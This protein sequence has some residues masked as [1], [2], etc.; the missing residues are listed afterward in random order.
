MIARI[1]FT[2]VFTITCN[3]FLNAQQGFYK[4]FPEK[5]YHSLRDM[6]VINDNHFAFITSDF[7]YRIDGTGNILLKKEIGHGSSS[8]V[9]SV[10]CD[11]EGNFWIAFISYN[12]QGDPGKVLY[13]FSPNGQVLKTIDLG[14]SYSVE[15]MKLLASSNN[16]FFLAYKDR[17]PSGNT[18]VRLSLLD[19]AGNT[20]WNKQ[21]TDTIYNRYAIK[22][23][24]NNTVDLYYELK[25]DRQ[26][27]IATIDAT[28]NI[29]LKKINL[30]DPVD[31]DYYTSD[32]VRTNDGIVFC[33][34]ENKS[35]PSLSDGLIYKA[36]NNGNILWQNTLNIKLSDNFYN[37][38]AVADG[39]IILSITGFETIA[40]DTEGDIVMIKIDKQGNKVWTKAFG[41]PKM[42]YARQLYVAGQHIA[43]AGQSSYPASSVSVPFVCKTDLNGNISSDLPF[44]P[45]PAAK[46]KSIET[47]LLQYASTMCQS[48]PGPNESI[49]SGGNFIKTEDDYTYPFITRSDKNAKQIWYKQLADHP[50]TLKVLKQ[51]RPNEYIA[52]T[53]MKDIFANLYDVY[54]LDETGKI[55]WT[56]QVS[57]SAIRDVIA[58][59]DGGLILAGTLDI[60]FINYETLL[61]KLDG[62][63]NEQW[64]KKIGD[65]RVWESGK[66]IIE[67]PEQDFL[68]V[69]SSQPEFDIVSSIY[70]L[71]INAQGNK[72]WS[73][74][75]TDG[76]SADFGYD[77]VITSDQGY[78]LAGSSNK[79]PFTN[80]DLLLIRTDKNGNQLWRKT[81]DIHLMDEGFQVINSSG[82]GFLVLGTTAEPQA[83]VLEKYIYVMK[84][85][86]NGSNDGIRYYG[87]N[88]SQTMHPSLTVL[89]SGDTII[90]GTA[91]EIYGEERLFMT[92][93]E[94]FIPGSQPER[95]SIELYPNP[96]IGSSSL[97]INTAETGDVIIGI[98][99]QGGRLI[100]Q[101]SRKKTGTLFKEDLNVPSLATGTYFVSVWFNGKRENIKWLIVK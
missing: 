88:G 53:E 40:S 84:T 32:F 67:T 44:E 50:A 65:L 51:I 20:I 25:D 1:I 3:L 98:Y 6:T 39:Y 43:F 15:T 27:Q 74:T 64:N 76:I 49:I 37:I 14:P 72:L 85:G 48:A 60:S 35:Y 7:F 70:V 2:L 58:T 45:A 66:K 12:S 92:T 52:V 19:K 99:D 80:K 29:S 86:V 23:G 34:L 46:M 22:K 26:G 42:D 93:L 28:G 71:K 41:G 24:I 4:V 61:I 90:T 11:Q 54:K 57:A 100:K 21:V 10:L 59:R 75:F 63:G 91:Q 87:K 77:V 89:S 8:S 68:I 38:E 17:S 96:S 97:V 18:A 78:L 95:S 16:T 62:S 69:G 30:I 31:S 47:P 82:G 33:G 9:E 56:K 5:D 81:Y 83:G 79:Q 94:E 101:I 13:K 55:A 73:K 36:D